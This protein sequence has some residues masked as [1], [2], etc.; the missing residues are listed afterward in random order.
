MTP[1]NPINTASRMESSVQN[2]RRII[3]L[4]AG[5]SVFALMIAAPGAALAG[6]A[7]TCAV[8][9][10]VSTSP[11]RAATTP[12]AV[13]LNWKGTGGQDMAMRLGVTGGVPE[14]EL[15]TINGQTVAQRARIEYRIT[16]GLRR[17]SNQQMVPLRE[18]GVEINDEELEKHKWDAF[19]DSPLD[20][21][22][23]ATRPANGPAFGGNP[24]P[25]QGVA[26]QPGLPRNPNEVAHSVATYAASGCVIASDGARVS[27]S[28]PNMTAGVF[29][30]QLVLTVYEGT[31]LIKSDYVAVTRSPSVAYKYNAG[32]TGLTAAPG[33]SVA[34]RDE[35]DKM[36]GYNLTGPVNENIVPLFANNRLVVASSG[37]GSIAAF[38]PPH[39]FFWA[40]EH[41]DN[42][43]NNWYRKD[44]NGTFSIGIRQP[45]MET[46]EPYFANWALYSAP[47]GTEQHMGAYFY[48]TLGDAG[49]AFDGALAFTSND[50]YP[51]LPGYK[52][53]ANHFHTNMGERLLAS[54]SIDTRLRDIEVMRSAGVDI[55]GLAERPRSRP[56]GPSRLET[57][58]ALY[59]GAKRHSDENF[60]VVPNFENSTIL[61][62]HWDMLLS[63]PVYWE[64]ERKDGEAFSSTDPKYGTVYRVKDAAEVMK[65]IEETGSLIY[66]PHP[67]TKGSTHY[68]DAVKDD[69][70]FNS[71][72]YRGVGWRWGMGSDLSETRLSEKRVLP[73][74]DEMNN[75][76]VGKPLKPKFLLAISETYQKQPGD[77][78]YANGPVNYIK[79]D[80]LPTGGD[81][82]PINQALSRGD[83][84]VSTGEVLIP[85]HSFSGTGRN[86]VATAQIRTTFPLDFVE[87][88]W[89]DGK[90]TRNKV[91]QATDLP[92]F[93]SKTFSVPFDATGARWVRFAAWDSAGNGAMT[94]PVQ[95]GGR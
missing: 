2:F 68:P 5:A 35:G 71:D 66:M 40:R 6:D 1:R 63:K 11:I 44:A 91:V 19:W 87:V 65:M 23:P 64:E 93:G 70:P 67:R 72:A 36:Q 7:L 79:L 18:L 82:S 94:Q 86:A 55:M 52:V 76:M 62:G 45:E 49:R 16:T 95:I 48:P 41:E 54:G 57:I 37:A 9:K 25:A 31:N 80:R 83:S 51:A 47:P 88:V 29:S 21:R 85:S 46:Y 34:W 14:I 26:S 89:G 61:G 60:L 22:T 59:E 10:Y 15:L 77:D 58:H 92:A 56:N 4:A 38:P 28:F 27:V 81:Y 75:W 12:N 90:T 32:I 30:G 69:A 50:R 84:F 78:V 74:Y 8:D 42:P 53:M 73:L 20:M 24:P 39:T 3:G 17:M 13:N 33:A 43:A